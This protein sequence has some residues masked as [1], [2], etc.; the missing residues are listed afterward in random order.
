M[1]KNTPHILVVDNNITSL[2]YIEFTLTS[3][4]FKTTL[5]KDG[6]EAIEK[7]KNQHFD[8]IISELNL[9]LM[10]GSDLV[11][12]IRKTPEYRLT[13]FIILSDSKEEETW[14]E[15]LNDGADDF[16]IKPFKQ[17]LFI[18]KIKA[19]LKKSVLRKK[20]IDSS[21]K[22]ILD[23]DNGCIIYCTPSTN[24]FKLSQH[25]IKTPIKHI[26][27]DIELFSYLKEK[28]VL[29]IIIDDNAIWAI[30]ILDKISKTTQHLIPI[31]ILISDSKDTDKIDY[32]LTNRIDFFLYKQLDER[33]ILHQINSSVQQALDIKNKYF[34]ALNSAAK[35]SPIRFEDQYSEDIKDF[36]IQVIHQAY[37]K[38]AGGDFYET[39]TVD[40]DRKII[41]VGDVMGKKWDAWFLVPAYI[42]YIRSTINFFLSRE[43]FDF[44]KSPSKFLEIIN[45]AIFKDLK[46]GEVFTTLSIITVCTKTS[47]ISIASAGALQPL[48]YNAKEGKLAQ[49]NITGT[50]LGVIPDARYLNLIQDV[51]QGDKLLLYTDG[52][53]EAVNDRTGCMI[54]NEDFLESI[55]NTIG[56][57]S[58]TLSDIDYQLKHNLNISKFDDDRTLLLVQKN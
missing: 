56:K 19:H 23:F 4:G 15:N 3:I 1:T 38:L 24:Q 30:S 50:L 53:I 52:Y 45:K 32:L 43:E 12:Q 51:E 55:N 41:V 47:Q 40:N 22:N 33:L 16:I 13:P 11:R 6:V 20:I 21:R 46:L 7:T 17:E 26:E 5:A 27:S 42:A 25:L 14:I 28:N 10:N 36:N 18:S 29:R 48:F 39:F 35:Q 58:I 2:K 34:N 9:P 37:N 31:D 54:G 49:L 44:F 57:E 8:L